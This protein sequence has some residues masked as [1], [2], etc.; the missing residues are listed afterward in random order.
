MRLKIETD[1]GLTG[2]GDATL[3]G[4]AALA[5]KYPYRRADPPPNRQQHGGTPW[6]G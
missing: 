3:H 2:I 4:H 6:H 1:Q 5:A